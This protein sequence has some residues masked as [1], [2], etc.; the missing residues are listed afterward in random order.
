M[1]S[2]PESSDEKMAEEVKPEEVKPTEAKPEEGKPA[3]ESQEQK[4]EQQPTS[5][6]SAVPPVVEKPKQGAV[7]NALNF[8]F[9]PQTGLGRFNRALVR[10]VAAIVGLFALGFLVAYLIIYRPAQQQLDSTQVDLKGVQQQLLDVQATLTSTQKGL[11]DAQGQ[12]QQSQATLKKTNLRVHLLWVLN[13]VNSARLALLNKDGGAAQNALNS[14]KSEIDAA[15]PDLQVF[16]PA[17]ANLIATR[18]GL[19]ISELNDPATAQAD[20]DILY[21]KLAEVDNALR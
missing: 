8:L 5:E 19:V 9:S 7:N 12:L 16:D 1:P 6:T 20:L 14:A 18:L 10:W 21:A 11:Q 2:S 15:M 3:E 13:Y 4:S 17:A